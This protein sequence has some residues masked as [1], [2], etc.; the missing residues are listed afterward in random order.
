[1]SPNFHRRAADALANDSLRTSLTRST[2]I[3]RQQQAAGFADA[4]PF[5]ELQ[6]AARALREDALLT[7]GS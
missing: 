7:L 2:G 4:A 5:S 6:A 1:M 3:L